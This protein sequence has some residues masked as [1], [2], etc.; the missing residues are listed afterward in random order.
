MTKLY[1]IGLSILL[2]A[3]IANTIAG[4]INVNTWYNF[5]NTIL[6]KR[7]GLLKI[8]IRGTRILWTSN[9]NLFKKFYEKILL[10]YFFQNFSLFFTVHCR[11]DISISSSHS[12]S[13]Q[14]YFYNQKNVFRSQNLA[15]GSELSFF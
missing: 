12:I 10:H 6:E 7:F 3:I 9:D 4:Y 2:T 11:L 5:S 13:R 15:L 14:I 8:K 1:I